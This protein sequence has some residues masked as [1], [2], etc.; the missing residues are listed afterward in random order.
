MPVDDRA[1]DLW[2]PLVTV[3]DIAGGA[4]PER[5]RDAARHHTY[6]EGDDEDES[7]GIEML[8]D[9]REVIALHRGDR[10]GSPNL[11]ILLKGTEE[12]R[13]AEEDL[14]PRRLAITLREFGIRPSR[15]P[16]GRGN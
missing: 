16:G 13:W 15:L 7:I 8:R 10:I 12:S 6:L 2:E 3:A 4:W 11:S 1:A 5:A 9:I 14:K